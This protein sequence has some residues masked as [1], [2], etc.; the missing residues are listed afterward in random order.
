MQLITWC[1]PKSVMLVH[2]EAEKMRFLKAKIKVKN[3]DRW[4]ES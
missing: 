4:K 1:E 2:G 3:V